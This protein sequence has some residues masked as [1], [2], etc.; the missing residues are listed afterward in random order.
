MIFWNGH[1]LRLYLF[2]VL[3]ELSALGQSVKPLFQTLAQNRANPLKLR[4]F[5]LHHVRRARV[6]A[7]KQLL[8][9]RDDLFGALNV[10]LWNHP[11][12]RWQIDPNGTEKSSSKYR[13]I[14]FH[15]SGHYRNWSYCVLVVPHGHAFYLSDRAIAFF[16]CV[17]EVSK[18]R[19]KALDIFTCKLEM[20]HF[21]HTMPCPVA[22][23]NGV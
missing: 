13:Y 10:S 5:R 15:N 19:Q 14:L 23:W 3:R 4:A 20:K 7:G 21:Y 8:S 11:L 6:P 18:V 16:V 1:L 9:S 2:N 12:L 17:W 22:P